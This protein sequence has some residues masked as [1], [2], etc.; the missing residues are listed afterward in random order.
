M[1]KSTIDLNKNSEREDSLNIISKENIQFIE[2]I[3]EGKNS[4]GDDFQI[5]YK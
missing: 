2:Q 5:L 3:G 1:T 4:T